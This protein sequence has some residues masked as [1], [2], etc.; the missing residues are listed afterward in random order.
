MIGDEC[1]PRMLQLT[2]M[3]L[4]LFVGLQGAG[5]STLY[6]QRFATTHARVSKDLMG[7]HRHKQRRQVQEL[8]DLLAAGHNVVVDNTNATVADRAPLIHLGREHGAT[9]IGYAFTTPLALCLARNAQRSGTSRVPEIALYAT[10]KRLV[11]PTYAEG[12]NEIWLVQPTEAG[13]MLTVRVHEGVDDG[14]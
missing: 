8:T 3:E 14:Q 13:A 6:A 9:V 2:G 1:A 11:I 7:H 5:K 10:R 12:F 4:V